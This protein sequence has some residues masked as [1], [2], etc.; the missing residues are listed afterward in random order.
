MKALFDTN[1]LI[2]HLN[3]FKAAKTE[4]ERYAK[5]MISRITWMEVMVGANAE[6]NSTIR[7][8][9]SAFTLVDLT[10]QIAERAVE[11]RKTHRLRLPDAIVWAS[12]QEHAAL[13]I[14]RDR[15]DFYANDP[16]IRIPYR[17]NI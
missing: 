7:Q 8:F 17:L 15:K 2:D 13:L 4:I 11:L 3:G 6:N 1:V 14:T 5:P 9:L 10:P 16:G 12:A